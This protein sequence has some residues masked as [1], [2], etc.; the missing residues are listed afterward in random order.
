[1]AAVI[2]CRRTR[3]SAQHPKL[4]SLQVI[5]RNPGDLH[6]LL[7]SSSPLA[8]LVPLEIWA[9]A[10]SSR[11]SPLAE[12]LQH[13]GIHISAAGYELCTISSEKEFNDASPVPAASNKRRAIPPVSAVGMEMLIWTNLWPRHSPLLEVFVFF[14]FFVSG[15]GG[16]DGRTGGLAVSEQIDRLQHLTW[17]FSVGGRKSRGRA[18]FRLH[19]PVALNKGSHVTLVWPRQ[20]GSQWELMSL[21]LIFHC[22]TKQERTSLIMCDIVVCVFK[23]NPAFRFHWLVVSCHVLWCWWG[24]CSKVRTRKSLTRTLIHC[25]SC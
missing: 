8:L 18:E 23:W 1:M 3:R 17:W 16:R 9:A 24:N 7:V 20:S 10:P 14:V 2:V 4:I 22:W 11:A 15:G 12:L 5:Q 25:C 19:H 21:F 6:C 13:S